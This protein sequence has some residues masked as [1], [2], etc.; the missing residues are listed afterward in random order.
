MCDNYW[1]L[2]LETEY[3]MIQEIV[4]IL[5]QLAAEGSTSR[6]RRYAVFRAYITSLPLGSR[7]NGFLTIFDY[8]YG[9]NKD[10]YIIVETGT[11]RTTYLNWSGDG[12]STILFDLFIVLMGGIL[13]S[14]DISPEAVE[15][16]KLFV[17][18]FVNFICG[19]SVPVLAELRKS[20]QISHIDL[21]YLDSYDVD[22]NAPHLSALHHMKELCSVQPLASGTMVAI[23]DNQMGVGKGQYV[24][25]YMDSIG[26]RPVFNE[27]Q[28]CYIIP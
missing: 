28:I 8:L 22:W 7:Q 19:D 26:L 21:L 9:L 25:S 16:A 1:I 6:D 4:Q 2:F 13:V 18:P 12:M 17:S 20:A 10:H 3:R 24:T 27:Y 14:I 15:N 23:D 5:Q 11:I